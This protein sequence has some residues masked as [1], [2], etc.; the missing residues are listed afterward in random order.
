MPRDFAAVLLVLGVVVP[1]RGYVRVRQLISKES[2]P[3][4]DRLVLYASTIGFQWLATLFV[5]W[6]SLAHG[7]TLAS[8][9]MQAPRAWIVL[10]VSVALSALITANQLASIRRLASLPREQQGFFRALTL[11]LMPHNSSERL[12][13]F[14]LVTTVSICEEVLY[15]GWAQLIFQQQFGGSAALAV[16]ASAAFFSLAHLYQG[17]RGVV[18]TFVVGALF[19]ATRAWT[20][21]LVPTMIAHFVADS[22]AGMIAPIWIRKAD[23][24]RL[25]ESPSIGT[26][27]RTNF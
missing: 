12:A 18:V 11:K 20:G 24:A 17:R 7:Y 27:M 1:W 15:R 13:F 5:L 19:S 2:L 4:A 14:A 8:L 23:E 3:S 21:S 10:A 25:H 16:L 26:A 6:R 22:A 9:G